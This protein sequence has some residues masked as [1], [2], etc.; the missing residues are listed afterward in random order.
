MKPFFPRDRVAV[1][2]GGLTGLTAA[3]H[4]RRAGMEPVVFEKSAR[5]GGAIGTQC[6]EGWMH[7]LGPNSLLEGSPE[8]AAFVEAIGLADRR[9]YAAPEARQRYIVRDGRLVA[10]PMSPLGFVT[11][12]LFS[13]PAKLKLLGEPW[14]SRSPADREESV[15]EFVER[16]LGREFLDYAIN[17]FVGGVY[18]G[19]PAGLSVRHAFPKLHALEQEHGSLIRGALKR[20]NTSGG[21]KGRIFSFQG[22][23]SELPDALSRDLGDAVRLRTAVNRVRRTE[24]GWKIT[25]ES[26][27]Q[28]FDDE[29]SA[30]LCALPAGALASLHW[31]GVPV[32]RQLDGLREIQHPPVVSVFTGYRRSDVRHP[33]DGFGVLVP[34]IEHRQILG[35]LF[36]STLF[37]G[38]VP[39]NRVAFTSFVGGTRQP[40]LAGLEDREIL[41]LVQDELTELV[42]VAASPV[43]THVQRW[44]HAIPQYTLGYQRFKDTIAAVEA[45]APGLFIGGNCRDGISLPNCIE[46]GRRLAQNAVTAVSEKNAARSCVSL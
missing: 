37:P 42:G 11:T 32:A 7:E 26:G 46:S 18:A 20:R 29:F 45:S 9:V 35:T 25:H 27:G 33:L 16:R 6:S 15:A 8:V 23:L 43:F 24:E 21:P 28:W 22:G 19:D 36:S 1:L 44:P 40:E 38:R 12:P 2:G 14:R 39:E 13:L 30:V 41:R 31:D 10:M 3:W 17:P 34:E 5:V 4:L